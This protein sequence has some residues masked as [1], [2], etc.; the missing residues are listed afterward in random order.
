MLTY[1]VVPRPRH[2]LDNQQ[3]HARKEETSGK[4]DAM[5]E[6]VWFWV[7]DGEMSMSQAR[8][9]LIKSGKED[10]QTYHHTSP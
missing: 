4:A 9:Q 7:R 1:I 3:L 2:T 10:L 5:Q 6:N 8:G